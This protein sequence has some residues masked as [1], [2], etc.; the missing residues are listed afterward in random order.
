MSMKEYDNTNTCMQFYWFI[1]T[2]TLTRLS[3]IALTLTCTILIF[4]N[5]SFNFSSIIGV[6][7]HK[8]TEEINFF[9][10]LFSNFLSTKIRS[11]FAVVSDRGLF[12]F[13]LNQTKILFKIIL[14][15]RENRICVVHDYNS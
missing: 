14:F 13:N 12:L 3:R 9:I 8:Y 10:C 5:F 4:M 6:T 11:R 1:I 2:T 7:N 15:V